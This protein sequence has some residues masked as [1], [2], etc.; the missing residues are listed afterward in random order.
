LHNANRDARMIEE[1]TASTGG[2]NVLVVT[3]AAAEEVTEFIVLSAKL[4]CRI[5]LLEA[6]HTSDPSFD[7][8]M[9][10]FKSIVQVHICPVADFAAQ[11]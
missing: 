9:V 4:A 3:A 5:M 2:R 10:L 7:P 11:R 6:A 1:V 8:T